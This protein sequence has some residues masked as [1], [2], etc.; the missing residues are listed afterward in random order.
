VTAQRICVFLSSSPGARPDYPA[1]ARDLAVTLAREGRTLVYGGASVGLMKEL[2]DAAVAAGGRVVGVIPER[3]VEREVAHHGLAELHIVPTMHARK[4]RMFQEADAFVVL[5]GGFGTFEEM[6]E[7]LTANQIGEHR[8]PLCVVDVC[9]FWQPMLAFLDHA[10]VEGVL[11]PDVRA[12]LGVAATPAA[13][14][15]W[16]DAHGPA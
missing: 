9:G 14:L 12:L 1:A 6:F 13:A 15:A 11:R 2:A 3:L 5:P 4:A 7:I 10:V 16:I 8:K